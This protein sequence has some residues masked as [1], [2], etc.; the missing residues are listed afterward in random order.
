[1]DKETW[2]EIIKNGA[3]SH[4]LDWIA[5]DNLGQIAIF[6]AIMEAPIPKVIGKSYALFS[7]L[8]LIINQLTEKGN[9]E[10]ITKNNRNISDWLEYSKKGL[11]AFDFQDVHREKQDKLEHYDLISIPSNPIYIHDLKLKKEIEG[12]IPKIDCNF[13]EGN[14]SN[15]KIKSNPQQRV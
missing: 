6:S 4:E 11:F 12:I 8:E 5:Q 1:M 3:Y 7:E 10:P 13:Q 15:E 9:A 2:N 14:V